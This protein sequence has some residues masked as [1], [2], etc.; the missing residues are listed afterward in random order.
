M[1]R[2]IV[3]FLSIIA[4]ALAFAPRA[5]QAQTEDAVTAPDQVIIGGVVV[6]AKVSAKVAGFMVIHATSDGA[7]VIGHTYVHAGENDN[8]AVSIDMGKATPTL[9]AMLH[10]DAG[11]PGVYEFPGPDAPVIGADQKP[12]SPEFKV[13][14]TDVDDQLLNGK[15]VTIGKI[16]AQDNGWIAI[17]TSANGFP[18]IGTAP[19]K[20]GI[21]EDVKV[22]IDPTKATDKMTAMI[23]IDAGEKGKYEFPGPD[24]PAS[25]NKAISNEPFWI[26]DHVRTLTQLSDGKTVTVPYALAKQDGWMAIHSTAAGFPVIGFA[27]IKKGLNEGVEVTIKDPKTLT[28][29]V[30]AMLHID[31]GKIGT[32]EFPG[33]D[34]PVM[35][36]DGKPVA[37]MMLVMQG[38]LVQDQ[39]ADAITKQGGVMVKAVVAEKN[40]WIVIH[41]GA[42]GS[43]VLGEA[44]VTA[45]ANDNILV[46]VK[47]GITPTITAMLHVDAG[48]AGVYE[49][50][51]PDAPVMGT[52]GKIINPPIKTGA[53]APAAPA[54]VATVNK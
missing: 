20:A 53:A 17:H 22:D 12:V 32:Y 19:I 35:G 52:D 29:T 40:G 15:T 39:T 28:P 4:F 18:V 26:T 8:V 41:S 31:A 54:A 23:H 42:S 49:F 38:V 48:K 13:I 16:I 34:A 36:A 33:P 1:S 30:L 47:E 3:S 6:I 50:P 27:P 43:P 9:L 5:V 44:Y 10:V 25:L 14:G 46:P 11:K 21:N 24:A 2:K 37:P 45:G 51:G 7:P